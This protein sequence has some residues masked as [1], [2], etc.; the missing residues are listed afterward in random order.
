MMFARIRQDLG[1]VQ[2]H[3]PFAAVNFSAS[4]NVGVTQ[5][6]LFANGK[7]V[8]EDNTSPFG[9]SWD[10]TQVADGSA[11][12]VAYAYDAANNQGLSKSASVTV[13]NTPELKDTTPPTV[14]ITSPSNGAKVAGTVSIN[15]AGNDNVGVVK[16]NCAVN[17]KILKEVNN[18]S[19]LTC[20]W[21]TRKEKSGTHT[22]SSTAKDAAGN[23]SSTS[24]SVTK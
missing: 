18:S 14:T 11:T 19:S 9:F 13:K 10:T 23:V 6:V 21:N 7:Q 20:S 16:L 3:I 5:V 24:I 8:A 17:G 12:L 22:I 15:V 4:D 2:T 1:S